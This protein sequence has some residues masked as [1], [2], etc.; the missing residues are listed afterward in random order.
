MLFDEGEKAHPDVFNVLLQVLDDG[1]ITDSQG[2]KVSFKNTIIIMTSNAG[3]KEIISP[4]HL[5]FTAHSDAASEHER[6]KTG[7]MDEVKRLFR[8]EFINRI[9][10]T[11]VFHMLDKN[12]MR[13]ITGLITADFSKRAENAFDIKL[14]VRAATANYL[15]DNF[16]D[17]VMGARPLKRAVQREIEDPLSEEILSGRI[18][19]G[20]EVNV[21]FK[22]NK[23]VF[24]IKGKETAN[25]RKTGG[26]KNGSGK[27]TDPHRK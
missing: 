24:E 9:D 6:M 7:V 14:K 23:A 27:R 18:K 11:I 25:S 20:D 1:H 16:S 15:A 19:Q 13:K 2:R 10:E 12:C 3:A 26:K 4:K 21:V 22:D 17:T 8:P 5:G